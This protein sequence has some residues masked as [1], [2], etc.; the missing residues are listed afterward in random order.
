[1]ISKIRI[2]VI[3]AGGKGTRIADFPLTKIL[4]KPMLPVINR[5][6]LEYVVENMKQ[7]GV[8]KIFF[9]VGHKSSLIKEYFGDGKSFKM[10]FIY[11]EDTLMLGMARALLLIE[12]LV[13]QPFLV[14]LGD[15][16]TISNSFPNIIAKFFKEKC[17]VVEA[18]IKEINLNV[19]KQTCEAHLGKN[20]L[21]HDLIEK[22][23]Q[24]TNNLRGCGIYVFSPDIFKYI[25]QTPTHHFTKRKELS[26]SI[27][28]VAKDGKAYGYLLKG[29]NININTFADLVRA[30]HIVL[31]SNKTIF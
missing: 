27:R 20:G 13:K 11:I 24:V 25:R 30:N 15:D 14:I 6:I 10:E 9:L 23:Q 26:D 22:P 4:P 12:T 7:A 19:I 18:V 21:L 28:L 29:K 2:G 17:I 8:E 16:M 5:P 31:N 1:M 3:P